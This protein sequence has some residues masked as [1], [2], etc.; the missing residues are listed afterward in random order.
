MVKRFVIWTRT[1]DQ[2]FFDILE[3]WVNRNKSNT[4]S[5]KLINRVELLTNQISKTPYMFRLT[6]FKDTRVATLGHFS[7]FYK[8]TD[9]E[10][11]ITTFWDNRQNPE[12][13]LNRLNKDT[14]L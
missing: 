5:T 8:I 9:H 4:Y 10:I 14:L 12:K 7:I 11:I 13:L 1:A 6:D 2:Q 3:Y